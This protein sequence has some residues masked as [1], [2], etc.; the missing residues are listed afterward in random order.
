[1][2]DG[3]STIYVPFGALQPDG[4]LFNNDGLVEARNVAPVYGNY[5]PTPFW[6]HTGNEPTTE[7]FGLHAHF[8]G[9][10][11]W[12][13]YLGAVTAL[14]EYNTT[15]WAATD[16]TR[17]VGGPYGAGGAG[18]E[19]GWQSAS[20]GD[21]IIMTDYVDDPQLLTSPA[22]ANF[23]K[24]AQS[25]G[26]NPGMD[27]KAK[28]VYS[29]RGNLHLANLNLPAAL[30]NPDGSTD[31]AAGAHP[32]TVC[33]SQTEN[34]RQFGS[35]NATPQLTGT[36]FQPLNY[37]FGHLAGVAGSNTFAILFL[38]KGIVRE[39]GP[40]Y[41]FRPI[42]AGSSCRYPN[43]IVM[44]DQDVYFWGPSGPSVLR[45]GEGPVLVL[46][47]GR[48][49]RTLIDNAAAG[50]SPTYSIS[51]SALTRHVNVSADQTNG[52]IYWTFTST[53]GTTAGRLGDLS[54]IYNVREDRFSFTDNASVSFDATT[55]HS[56]GLLFLKSGPDLGGAWAPGRDLVGVMRYID[57][58]P[59]THYQIAR[60]FY[61]NFVATLPVLL[62][63]GFQQFDPDATTRVLGVRPILT[64]STLVNLLNITVT[65]NSKN[66]PYAA[67]VTRTSNTENE[68]GLY[69]F[70][71]SVFADFHQ[72]SLTIDG[73]D[74]ETISELEGFEV[75]VLKGGRY[76]A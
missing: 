51:T 29:L 74:L 31:L 27:P 36:G 56:N 18:G 61:D 60:V 65:L 28:F 49:A 25:G 22:A 1:M 42:V 39:D 55:L 4:K 58:T 63:K 70:P 76:S 8:A 7:P 69:T 44:F 23:V 9:S 75:Q 13:A 19:A 16:K 66:K 54:I 59:T 30:L 57:N 71:T 72:I 17:A 2:P 64:R 48:V 45:G 20:F 68:H 37:D 24:L 41:T 50:F 12:F 15:T 62:T 26:A 10:S 33:W 67:A 34:V 32:T 43:S 11:S 40:P 53:S 14:Y 52:L 35:F 21:S 47:D 3:I 73:T 5:I 38:Q 6:A 46:G